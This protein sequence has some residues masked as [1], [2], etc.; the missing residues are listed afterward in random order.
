[1]TEEFKKLFREAFSG[2]DVIFFVKNRDEYDNFIKD[3]NSIGI[4]FLNFSYFALAMDRF[5]MTMW[6]EKEINLVILPGYPYKDLLFEKCP[7]YTFF[8]DFE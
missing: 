4:D 8:G 7:E 5:R 1:M 3:M 6:R 2:E